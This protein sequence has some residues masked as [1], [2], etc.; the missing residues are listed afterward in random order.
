[1]KLTKEQEDKICDFVDSQGLQLQSLRDDI[2]DHLC[3]VIENE[4]RRGK[5]FEKSLQDALLELAPNGLIDMERKTIF[6]LNSKRIIMMKKLMYLIGFIGSVVL[7]VG[8]TFKLLYYPYANKLLTIGF[9][10]LLLVYVPLLTIDKYKVAI[11]KAL[12][13]RLKIILGFTAGILLGLSVLF[14]V[15]HFWG[16]EILLLAGAVI[17]AVGYLPFLF[18]TMYKRSIA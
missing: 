15:M 8:V 11:G 3:C 7:T 13:E 10:L 4:L 9:L 5:S 2:L 14:K 18:F 16:A 17:F 12:S 1:M 6:L